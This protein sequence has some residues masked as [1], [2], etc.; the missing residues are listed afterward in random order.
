M[1]G[2]PIGQLIDIHVRYSL[3]RY[4]TRRL[5]PKWLRIGIAI[6]LAGIGVGGSV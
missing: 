2:Q 3:A 4:T 1:M 5:E 6:A